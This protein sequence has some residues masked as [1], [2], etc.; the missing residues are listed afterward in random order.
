VKINHDGQP[1]GPTTLC[2]TPASVSAGG[3]SPPIL[4]DP[5]PGGQ[6]IN[7]EDG[8]NP[9]RH[10]TSSTLHYTSEAW[11]LPAT[12]SQNG[13]A[14]KL[15]LPWRDDP[16]QGTDTTSPQTPQLTVVAQVAKEVEKLTVQDKKHGE[17]A[18]KNQ[19]GTSS[20]SNAVSSVPPTPCLNASHNVNIKI[21][22]NN[23]GR[24]T[25]DTHKPDATTVA[26][27]S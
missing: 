11:Y 24:I 1:A 16:L 21:V 27:K 23:T 2:A 8:L 19:S 22:N 12:S 4:R 7:R 9:H 15:P 20:G 3:Y 14:L 6:A 17:I 18:T 13:R 25:D 10:T 5:D 26:K